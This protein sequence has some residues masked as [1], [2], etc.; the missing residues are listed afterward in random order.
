MLAAAFVA[1]TLPAGATDPATA[2][3]WAVTR[4]VDGSLH[5][6]K[7][8]QASVAAM[9]TQLGRPGDRVLSLEQDQP[10]KAMGDPLRPQQW[11]LDKVPFE[12][13]W[14]VSRGSGV[15]VAVVD[16]GVA[17]AHQDLNGSVVAGTDFASDQASVDPW[18][19][20]MVDP[21]GHGTHVAGIIAAHVEQRC[22]NCRRG[23]RRQDHARA[24]AR[25]ERH[26]RR[27]R[28]WRSASSGRPITA[29]ASS[30]SA[31]AVVRRPVNNRHCSTRSRRTW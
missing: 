24:C 9:D 13:A 26:R 8:A 1:G 14:G 6:V 22:R 4:S 25:R 23:T 18:G 15:T 3:T 29:R 17:A 19:A 12:A 2:N 21:A 27:V 20:G 28:M 7:G 10:V 5:V 16:T 30:T 11:A 31:S